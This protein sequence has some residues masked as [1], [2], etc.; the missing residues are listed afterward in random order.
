[1]QKMKRYFLVK[2]LRY[3]LL[4]LVVGLYASWQ[5]AD[6]PIQATAACPSTSESSLPSVFH[7]TLEDYAN[8]Q[9]QQYDW[10]DA[11][12]SSFQVSCNNPENRLRTRRYERSANSW[13]LRINS[14]QQHAS[15]PYYARSISH[16]I[17]RIVALSRTM[18]LSL[19]TEQ[20]S[21]PFHS[22]W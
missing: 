10:T 4:L 21:F 16:S 12:I 5:R 1:M 3:I 13:H 9:R 17:N 8:R 19:P 2:A 11:I 20:I 18:P 22:F 14:N 7:N 6:I 15:L